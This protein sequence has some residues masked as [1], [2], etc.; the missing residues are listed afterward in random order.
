MGEFLFK[1]MVDQSL[2]KEGMAVPVESNQKILNELKI[3]LKKGDKRNI[4]IKIEDKEYTATLLSIKYKDTYTN[5]TA[6]QIKY[7]AQSL[8]CQVLNSIFAYS[9]GNIAQR[10]AESYEG[11][12]QLSVEDEYIEVYSAG[13]GALKF[14][15]HTKKL[16]TS[17]RLIETERIRPIIEQFP[18]FPFIMLRFIKP[19]KC[20]EKERVK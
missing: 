8:L 10:K 12:R 4:A 15:C 1:K 19:I 16:E 7:G 9:A 6:L 14:I 20:L 18:D 13:E 2:L 11:K 17:E 5:R 3:T